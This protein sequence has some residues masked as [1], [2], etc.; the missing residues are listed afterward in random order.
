M[1]ILIAPPTDLRTFLRLVG[2]GNVPPYVDI[3]FV[4]ELSAKPVRSQTS[5]LRVKAQ[6]SSSSGHVGPPV[7]LPPYILYR[8]PSIQKPPT[9]WVA[10][11]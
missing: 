7:G 9:L 2:V 4:Y 3:T 10:K 8:R 1:I 6:A 11:D 5:K